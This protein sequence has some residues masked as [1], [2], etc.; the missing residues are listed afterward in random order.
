M[1]GSD[2]GITEPETPTLGTTAT[3]D[4]QRTADPTG[5]I[6]IVDVVGSPA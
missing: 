1:R 2:R 3:V 6:T 4:G 5:E